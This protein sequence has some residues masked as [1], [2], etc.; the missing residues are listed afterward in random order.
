MIEEAKQ[1]SLK[2]ERTWVYA[3]VEFLLGSVYTQ[4][5]KGGKPIN[6]LAMAKNIGFLIRNVPNASKKAEEHFSKA[7]EVAKE[8]GA[9]GLLGP[10]YLN[11]GLLHKTKKKTKQ[12]K[13]CIMRAIE[14]FVQSDAEVYLKQANED[15]ESLK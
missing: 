12:A 7:I 4:I 6:L 8:I 5:V 15:L 9:N 11:L 13:E 2:N 3:F 14:I 1:S 10:A